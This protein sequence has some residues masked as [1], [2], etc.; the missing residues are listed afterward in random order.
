MK[1]REILF[2]YTLILIINLF[3]FLIAGYYLDMYFHT[4]WKLII[5]FLILSIVSLVILT[6]ILIRKNLN[7]LN[8]IIKNATHK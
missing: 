2:R 4:D 8:K 7:K 5:L 1:K 3:V 6:Q